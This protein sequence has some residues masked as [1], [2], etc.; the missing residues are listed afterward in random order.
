MSLSRNLLFF[1]TKYELFMQTPYYMISRLCAP[2]MSEGE[3]IWQEQRRPPWSI[4]SDLISKKTRIW[5]SR[6]CLTKSRISKFQN[7]F[8][9]PEV[10]SV[11]QIILKQEI[12]PF[13]HLFIYCFSS[14]HFRPLQR[15]I[16]N[17]RTWGK[18]R[19]G[20]LTL[21]Q[22]SGVF[23]EKMTSRFTFIECFTRFSVSC[24]HLFIRRA[25]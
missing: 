17:T 22:F 20:M 16:E 11:F 6:F 21:P 4:P 7:F 18:K 12:S 1:I 2:T 25:C 9:W 14:R 3:F 24:F 13:L 10:G 8:F 23:H 5:I 19:Q 15:K